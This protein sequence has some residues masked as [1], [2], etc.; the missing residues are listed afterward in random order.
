MPL[1]VDQ[2]PIFSLLEDRASVA[3]RWKKWKTRFQF[4]LD[5][6][7]VTNRPQRR[8]LL[9]HVAGPEVQVIFS[10]LPPPLTT[11]EEIQTALD[12]H[13]TPKTNIRYERVL[14]RQVRQEE[15]ET[16]DSFVTRLRKLAETCEFHDTEDAILDQLIERCAYSQLRRKALQETDLTLEKMLL[17]ARAMEASDRQAKVIEGNNH[18]SQSAKSVV[19]QIKKNARTKVD[20]KNT[21][22]T[23]NSKYKL[24]HP[25][26]PQ[27]NKQTTTNRKCYRCDYTN[28]A[29]WQKDKCPAMS[30]QCSSC[31]KIG[32]FASMCRTKKK[33][34]ATSKPTESN[35]ETEQLGESQDNKGDNDLHW[36]FRVDSVRSSQQRIMLNITLNGKPVNMQLDTAADVTLVSENLARSIP[37]VKIMPSKVQLLDYS[38]NNIK[39][40]GAMDVDAGYD[41]KE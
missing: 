23:T 2:P 5:A 14:F 33:V 10:T 13:F 37:N 15:C 21:V 9:L 6:K 18:S 11:Y 30:Q 22:N 28:H 17:L 31:K 27:G 1:D 12:K 20:G 38:G 26:Q 25:T 36:A 24:S 40:V 4:Y 34:Y 8:A 7:G 16:T 35:A 39:V 32:H 19:N 29:P 3:I 41:R